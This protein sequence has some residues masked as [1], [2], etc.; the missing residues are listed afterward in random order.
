MPVV[1]AVERLLSG[2]ADVDQ[3]LLELLSRPPRQEAI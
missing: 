3:V 2:E 1:A